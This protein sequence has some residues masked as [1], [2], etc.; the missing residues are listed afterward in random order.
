MLYYKYQTKE[1]KVKNMNTAKKQIFENVEIL[2]NDLNC[3]EDIYMEYFMSHLRQSEDDIKN[4]RVITLEEL[5]K[6]IDELEAK[7]ES[8][9]F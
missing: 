4:G 9:N 6:H 2:P 8:N 7:Y 5:R 3:D 1:R